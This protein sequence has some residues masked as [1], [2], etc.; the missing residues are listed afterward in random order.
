MLPAKICMN[1][2][3]WSTGATHY[4]S[5]YATYSIIQIK[6]PVSK[7]SS[8]ILPHGV[9]QL[10]ARTIMLILESILIVFKKAISCLVALCGDDCSMD[11]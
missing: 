1:F 2:N 5:L 9:K 6:V 3:G 10:K 7:T 11:Q 4:V 8:C